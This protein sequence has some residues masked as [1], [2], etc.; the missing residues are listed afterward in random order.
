MSDAA[1]ATSELCNQLSVEKLSVDFAGYRAVDNVTF[2]VQAGSIHCLIGPNG[3]GKSTCFNL[4]TKFIRP[5]SG[6]IFLDGIDVTKDSP[7]SIARKGVVRSFQISATFGGL[8][9]FENVCVALQSR[10][11]EAYR[12]RRSDSALK[13]YRDEAD[14]LL[15]GVGLLDQRTADVATLSYGRKRALEIATTLALDPKILLLD[16]PM[17]G[18]ASA[19]VGRVV[20]LLHKVRKGRTILMVEHNLRAVEEVSDT[21]TV[22][23]RGRILAE[24][25]Y[26]E[27]ASD[28]QVKQA[29][30]GAED[31]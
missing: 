31:V 23:A 14:S 28:P 20:E 19:D 4:I 13:R 27:V 18:M 12:W 8:N 10:N 15:E 24:G 17:A 30:L 9:V 7:V 11:R 16:E 26:A 1:S 25:S 5:T 29:Y 21:V 2:A 22:L 6:R 3:A